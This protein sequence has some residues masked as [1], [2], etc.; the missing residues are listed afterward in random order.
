MSAPIIRVRDVM[1]K[2]VLS[3]EGMASIKEAAAMMRAAKVSELLVA[4]R[5]DDDAWGIITIMDLVKDVIVPGHEGESVFV[6]E[7]MTKPVITIPAQMDI[8][9]AI[10]LIQRIGVHRA[11]VE[12]QGGIIGMVTLSSLI[13]D[14]DL[15]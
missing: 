10:R 1:Q 6:Y 13:L 11:P 8:R 2:E 12:H 15:L 4:K 5:D 14:N 3:I 9:Y 7:I